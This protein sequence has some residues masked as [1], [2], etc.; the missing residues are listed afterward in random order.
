MNLK[1]AFIFL[2]IN[3]CWVFSLHSQVN[4]IKFGYGFLQADDSRIEE[5]QHFTISNSAYKIDYT[6]H[7][8]KNIGLRATLGYSN[9]DVLGGEIDSVTQRSTQ[10]PYKRILTAL[11]TQIG[12]FEVQRFQ[13]STGFDIGYHFANDQT[14][15]SDAHEAS[16]FDYNINLLNVFYNYNGF[17][18]GVETYIGSNMYSNVFFSVGY[19]F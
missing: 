14:V 18:L 1:K 7:I 8:Y 9:Y 19:A 11:G 4:Q 6:R 12:L 2:L 13:F 3:Y 17:L 16:Y 5:R 15:R 10:R